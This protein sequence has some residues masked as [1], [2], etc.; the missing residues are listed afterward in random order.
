MALENTSLKT[1]T[2][3]V[4]YNA[5]MQLYIKKGIIHFHTQQG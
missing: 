4:F 5:Q 1:L 2:L 3:S